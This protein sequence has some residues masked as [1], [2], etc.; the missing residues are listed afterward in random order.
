MDVE[1]TAAAEVARRQVRRANGLLKEAA[2]ALAALVYGE[3]TVGVLRAHDERSRAQAQELVTLGCA[4]YGAVDVVVIGRPTGR[5][6][7]RSRDVRGQ[8]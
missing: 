4:R 3:D 5:P 2:Q 7:E 1:Q 8:H 6:K